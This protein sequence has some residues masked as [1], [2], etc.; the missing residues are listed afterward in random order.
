MPLEKISDTIQVRT[1]RGAI[2]DEM[3]EEVRQNL[4]PHPDRVKEALMQQWNLSEY[5]AGLL[6]KEEGLAHLFE[7]L[8]G[9]GIEAK[10]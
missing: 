2:T 1:H 7:E 6:V 9:K 4:P 5:D 3:L 8:T 10:S